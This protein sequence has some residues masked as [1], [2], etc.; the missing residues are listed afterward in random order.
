M[1]LQIEIE[2]KMKPA[3]NFR[4]SRASLYRFAR[5]WE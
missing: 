2:G 4:C 3:F 5:N 1:H